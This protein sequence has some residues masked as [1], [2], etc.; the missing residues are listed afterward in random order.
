MKPVAAVDVCMFQNAMGL[1]LTDIVFQVGG[2]TMSGALKE[3][4]EPRMKVRFRDP[5]A[6]F[7]R[8]NFT[9]L[10]LGKRA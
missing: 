3:A 6:V 5:S 4:V 1:E 8:K 10:L 7:G 9:L 2:D